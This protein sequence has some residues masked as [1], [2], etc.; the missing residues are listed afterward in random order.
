MDR[1]FWHNASK[2]IRTLRYMDRLLT[3]NEIRT[4]ISKEELLNDDDLVQ[5]WQDGGARFFHDD[6]IPNDDSIKEKE[7]LTSSMCLSNTIKEKSAE[8]YGFLAFNNESLKKHSFIFESDTIWISEEKKYENGWKDV[9]TNYKGKNPLCNAMIINDKFICK[10]VD[11]EGITEDLKTLLDALLPEGPQEL[12]F[13]LSI[14]CKIDNKD[15]GN[16]VYKGLNKYIAEIRPHLNLLL[17]LYTCSDVHDRF[18]LTN[19]Y[20]MEVGAG[21]NLF[22]KGK[23]DNGSSMYYYYP[24][25][26]GNNEIF[27]GKLKQVEKVHR[28]A[29][30]KEYFRNFWG[31]KKNRLF[32]ILN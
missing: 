32:D 18:V 20:I 14:F 21:F 25:V 17:S 13:H 8:R 26:N 7:Y 12:P 9:C 3:R 15:K 10:G 4:N 30:Q 6:K 1:D 23:T 28:S 19:S 27:I 29:Y 2:D 11:S 22:K 31:E 5:L 24:L 16:K